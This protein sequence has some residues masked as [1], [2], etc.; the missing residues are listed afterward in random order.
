MRVCSTP[1]C[2]ELID[3]AGRC[4]KHQREYEAKRGT[5]TERGY[6][7]EHQALRKQWTPRVA[8]G[9]IRCA[10]CHE[11]IRKGQTWA[12]D[13]RDDRTGYLGPSHARCNN[14]AGGQLARH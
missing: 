10:R 8:T 4:A 2:P 1:K 5:K 7:A 9:T 13:H 14:V 11:L 12:L 6:G 3:H